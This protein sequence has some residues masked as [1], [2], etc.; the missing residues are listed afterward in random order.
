MPSLRC[1]LLLVHLLCPT[2]R[3][4]L[5]L[6]LALFIH[7]KTV[8]VQ[9][10]MGEARQEQEAQ[11]EDEKEAQMEEEEAAREDGE[12]EGEGGAGTPQA[13]RKASPSARRC[14]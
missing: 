6:G 5:P 8:C 10:P 4:W 3:H 7:P 2:P 9:S 1:R 12:G 13:Q 11:D 14:Q